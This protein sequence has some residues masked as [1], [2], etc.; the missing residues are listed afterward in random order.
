[1]RRD[2][3]TDAQLA[4]ANALPHPRDRLLRILALQMT[5]ALSTEEPTSR[6]L[7]FALRLIDAGHLVPLPL[8][9]TDTTGL[10]PQV[11]ADADIR[12]LA[13][14]NHATRELSG[15]ARPLDR[16]DVQARAVLDQQT[17]HLPDLQDD[18]AAEYTAT[19][20][21]D[22]RRYALIGRRLRSVLA[23]PLQVGGE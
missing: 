20:R 13:T 21:Q 5:R 2:R 3:L 10:P 15:E 8:V 14:M 1:S 7:R 11:A 19:R 16:A 22:D 18:T 23:V 9:L 4:R 12:A 17:I 6:G